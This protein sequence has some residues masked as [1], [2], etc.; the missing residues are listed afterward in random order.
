VGKVHSSQRRPIVPTH[1]LLTVA[2]PP[3]RTCWVI[4]I[5]SKLMVHIRYVFLFCNKS[6]F[7]PIS[8]QTVGHYCQIVNWVRALASNEDNEPKKA[9]STQLQLLIGLLKH[10]SIIILFCLSEFVYVHVPKRN[11]RIATIYL[12]LLFLKKKKN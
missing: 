1:C 4:V 7:V 3:P 6:R 9:F 10:V 2:S 5:A 11:Q 8:I 12:L